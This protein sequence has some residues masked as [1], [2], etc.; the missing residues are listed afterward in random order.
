M[1][2]T[3]TLRASVAIARNVAVPAADR[4]CRCIGPRRIVTHVMGS[5]SAP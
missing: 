1:T 5:V 2:I 4:T 3:T